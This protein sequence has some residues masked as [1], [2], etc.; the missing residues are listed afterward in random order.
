MAISFWSVLIISLPFKNSS[1]RFCK[2]VCLL[3]T[4]ASFSARFSSR[5]DYNIKKRK[6]TF[7]KSRTF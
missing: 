5:R 1:D 6:L 3:T 7:K 4:M 2:E